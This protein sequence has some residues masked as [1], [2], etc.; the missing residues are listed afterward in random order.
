MVNSPN[1]DPK[2][3]Y[4]SMICGLLDQV[5]S[6]EPNADDRARFCVT[7]FNNQDLANTG[8]GWANILHRLNEL[9]EEVVS[10]K[11]NY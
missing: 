7:H 8:N 6:V 5:L 9:N 1:A 3:H 10:C 2:G 4:K 11:S